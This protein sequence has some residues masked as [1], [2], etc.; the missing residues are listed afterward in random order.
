M[1]NKELEQ[2]I[3]K[4]GSSLEETKEKMFTMLEKLEA[5]IKDVETA[6]LASEYQLLEAKNVVTLLE[7]ES[8]EILESITDDVGENKITGVLEQIDKLKEGI[9]GAE[10]TIKNAK[11]ERRADDMKHAAQEMR[12]DIDSVVDLA[13]Q[14]LKDTLDKTID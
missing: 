3:R 7:T 11:L 8:I 10:S 4:L 1:K 9:S 6:R 14:E 12:K 2:K 5:L 13:I